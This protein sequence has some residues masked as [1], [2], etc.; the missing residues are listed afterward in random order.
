MS[1][2]AFKQKKKNDQCSMFSW[3]WV[4]QTNLNGADGLPRG[5]AALYSAIPKAKANTPG[6]QSPL[7]QDKTRRRQEEEMTGT[8][9]SFEA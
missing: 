8:A 6:V 4:K 5:S 7:S 2:V 1:I 3:G 9:G